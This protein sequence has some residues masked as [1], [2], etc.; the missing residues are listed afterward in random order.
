MRR[1]GER[2]VVAE[3]ALALMLSIG[4]GLLVRSLLQLR[5]V[6]A[7][8]DPN[9]VLAV[10]LSLPSGRYDTGA[11]LTTFFLGLE[12]R[13]RGIP[14]VQGAGGVSQLS[15]TNSGYTS[16]FTIAGWPGGKYGS[17][18]VH[19]RVTPDYFKVMKTPMLAGRAFTVDDRADGPQV[20][21]INEAFARKHFQGEDPIGKRVTFDRIPDSTSTWNTIVGVVKSQHQTKLSLE[22][23]IEAFEPLTQ[24]PSGGMSMVLRTAWGSGVVRS[25]GTAR[26]CGDRPDAGDRINAYHARGAG[27]VARARAVPDDAAAP[28]RKRGFGARGCRSLRRDG[29]DGA[30]QNA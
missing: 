25:S 15:L 7:G 8:F 6:D 16:D 4:A 9:G 27:A 17:E 21:I 10:K 5:N 26:G 22:P 12:E 11:K 13:L 14:G 28:V 20:I 19:R 1:W 30:P 24:S 3:V 23:Q 18:V 29:A 2:L